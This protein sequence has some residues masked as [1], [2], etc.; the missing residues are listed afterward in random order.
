MPHVARRR[1]LA[2][3]TYAMSWSGRG[4]ASRV[5][6]WPFLLGIVLLSL[7]GFGLYKLWIFHPPQQQVLSQTISLPTTINANFLRQV[8]ACFIPTSAVYGYHLAITSGFRSIQDQNVIY[9]QGRTTPGDIVTNAPGG[10]SLHNYGL[11]VDVVDNYRS[12]AIDWQQ[13]GAI[14]SYC[15]L[16]HGDRGAVDLPHFQYRGGL[17]LNQIASGIVPSKLALPCSIMLTRFTA[18]K[19]LTRGDL[20]AC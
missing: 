6:R 3:R 4:S 2:T 5:R 8:T 15:G 17:T 11:A 14:G 7:A 16:E 9:A 10:R 18:G 1:R 12:Y 19:P 13:L 20:V